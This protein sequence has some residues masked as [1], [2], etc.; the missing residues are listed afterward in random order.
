MGN[1]DTSEANL[2]HSLIT[3]IISAI[4]AG[5]YH[6]DSAEVYGNE[7]ELGRAIKACNV[8]R[9]KLFVTAK[10]DGTKVQD[11]FESF[12]RSLKNLGLEYVDLYLIH[13]PYFASSPADLRA[14]WRDLEAIQ[15]SGKAKSIG[16][17]N[18]LQP[19]LE[20]ILFKATAIPAVNQIEFHPYLQHGRLLEFH[21]KHGIATVAYGPLTAITKASPG[22]LDA[23]YEELAKKYGVGAAEIALRWTID[24]GIV[25]LTT[26]SKEQRLKHYLKVADFKL[27][28]E[29]VE[30]IGE[31]GN[32]KHFRGFW[33]NKFNQNDRS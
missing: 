20:A 2:S 18:F 26:S 4:H 22:P 33:K 25:T 13:A 21:K 28:P 1:T 16:V 3:T 15:A 10:I 24:K 7:V 6:L 11:T 29:E 30:E 31:I 19:D 32:Q 14:K 8:P 9:E 23:K 17:S 5:Y 12:E 27:T